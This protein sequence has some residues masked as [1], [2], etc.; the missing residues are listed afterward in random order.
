VP[1][2]VA[3]VAALEQFQFAATDSLAI[4]CLDFVELDFAELDSEKIDFERVHFAQV[5][6]QPNL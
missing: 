4:A 1:I 5:K 3:L 2:V 6:E